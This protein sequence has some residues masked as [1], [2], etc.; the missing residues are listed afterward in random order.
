MKP[1]EFGCEKFATGKKYALD[2]DLAPSVKGVSLPVLLVRGRNP[3]KTLVVTAGIHGDEYEGVRALL[4]TYAALDPDEMSGNFLAVPVANPPALWAASRTSPLDGANLARIFP[5]SND[6]GPSCFIAYVLANSVIAA[7]DFYLDLHSAGVKLLMPT[8][9]GY[10]ATN[11]VARDAALIFGAKVL[12]AHPSVAPGRTTYYA[13]SRGI[14]WAYTEARGGGRIHPDDLNVF[15]SGVRNLLR[16]LSILPGKPRLHHPHFDLYGD[17][18]IDNS[19]AAKHRGLLI[20]RAELLEEVVANQEL[21][22]IVDLHGNEVER[23]LAPSAGRVVL[24]RQCL[25][26]EPGDSTFLLTGNYIA[27]KNSTKVS[28]RKS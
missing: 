8:L 6:S 11:P 12:W 10:S 4:D 3:G 26:V 20:P 2:L 7:A 24:I 17:D 19:V 25:S 1:E 13:Q 27:K 5:G 14:P 15:T 16:F 21:G 9:L 22:Q 28:T 23:I 18:N